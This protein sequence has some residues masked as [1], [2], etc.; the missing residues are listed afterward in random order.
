MGGKTSGNYQMGW[1]LPSVTYS[2]PQGSIAGN[3]GTKLDLETPKGCSVAGEMT[4]QATAL[5]S[6]S[7]ISLQYLEP[8]VKGE[9][10]LLSIVCSPPHIHVR[11]NIN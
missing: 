10:K 9:A 5:T 11:T 4:G 6:K 8:T 7:D 3:Q 2:V 1:I